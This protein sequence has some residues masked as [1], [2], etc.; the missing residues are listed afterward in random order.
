MDKTRIRETKEQLAS[1]IQELE[2]ENDRLKQEN[3]ELR[4]N[5]NKQV[6]K[7]DDTEYMVDK[8]QIISKTDEFELYKTYRTSKLNID[9][10]KINADYKWA[11]NEVKYVGGVS[12]IRKLNDL[13]RDKEH[14][15][16]KYEEDI[17]ER[18]Y[19]IYNQLMNNGLNNS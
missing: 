10:R 4:T 16:A 9:M 11:K 6:I 17:N 2:K 19:G 7:Y 3:E 13:E 12:M 8:N 1:R 18:G 5:T 14:I 15:L